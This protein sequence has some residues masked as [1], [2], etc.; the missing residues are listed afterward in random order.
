MTDLKCRDVWQKVGPSTS[1]A[2]TVE[3]INASAAVHGFSQRNTFVL[4]PVCLSPL[5]CGCLLAMIH[6]TKQHFIRA[7][8]EKRGFCHF[9][10]SLTLPGGGSTPL[11]SPSKPSTTLPSTW[12]EGRGRGWINGWMKRRFAHAYVNENDQLS[13]L[14]ASKQVKQ[15]ELYQHW[16]FKNPAFTF[17]NCPVFLTEGQYNKKKM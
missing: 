6:L 8:R 15:Q 17:V 3:G 12:T 11:A 2:L 1:R 9:T 5:S 10:E 16:M 7:F 13:D 4:S 14:E